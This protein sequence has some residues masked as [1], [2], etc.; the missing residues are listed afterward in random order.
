MPTISTII[1]TKNEA[2]NIGDCIE[3]VL[4]TDEIIVVDSGSTDQTQEICKKYAPKVKFHATDWPGFGKQ[5]NRALALATS[6][7]VLSL[8]ADE[9]ITQELKEE[10]LQKAGKEK[11]VAYKLLRQNYFLGNPLKYCSGFQGDVLV[12]LAKKEHCIFSDDTVH[13]CMIINNDAIGKMYN[14]F[15]HFSYR[16]LEDRIN[17]MNYY[18]TIG[19]LSLAQKNKKTY[20]F[21]ILAKTIWEFIRVYFLKLG[22]LDGW[23]GFIISLSNSEGKFYKYAKLMEKNIQQISK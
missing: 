17:K 13:E 8:D 23:P 9:R 15:K 16:S 1:I 22:F 10:I 3:S 21:E 6:E 2:H 11:Y 18:S 4:W 7:W 12:R 14:K 5:K 19:A 20:I